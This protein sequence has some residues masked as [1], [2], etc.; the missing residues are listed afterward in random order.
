VGRC[1]CWA[2]VADFGGDCFAGGED[3]QAGE[4]GMHD[5]NQVAWALQ[6]QPI[7]YRVMAM[8][9]WGITSSGYYPC[10]P[11][12]KPDLIPAA[13]SGGAYPPVPSAYPG[14]SSGSVVLCCFVAEA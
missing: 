2:M 11:C 9:A 3:A 8:V 1:Y 12:R 13:L 5:V 6:S 14:H 4:E 7:S 10:C